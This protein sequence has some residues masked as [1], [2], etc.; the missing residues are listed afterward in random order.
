MGYIRELIVDDYF[1]T[2]RE[3]GE[4]RDK[5]EEDGHIYPV[6]SLSTPLYRLI[7]AKELRRM[8]EDGAWRYV[9]R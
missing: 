2:K 7:K 5:L 1:K 3:I 4:V 8:K 9:N 6:T